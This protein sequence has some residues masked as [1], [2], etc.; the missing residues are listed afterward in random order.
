MELHLSLR[1]LTNILAWIRRKYTNRQKVEGGKEGEKECSDDVDITNT[2]PPEP[3]V[4][5][6]PAAGLIARSFV[7]TT[8][9]LALGYTAYQLSDKELGWF[10]KK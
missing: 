2:P 4:I 5:K 7:A 1:N 9:I 3:P 8:A 6:P 10:R